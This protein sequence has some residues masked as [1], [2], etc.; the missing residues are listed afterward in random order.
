MLGKNCGLKTL[1]V[2]SGVES[3]DQVQEW[4]SGDNVSPEQRDRVADFFVNQLGD[5]LTLAD[6][7]S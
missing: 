6:N 3:L 7:V 1:M 2:G 4:K 5:L